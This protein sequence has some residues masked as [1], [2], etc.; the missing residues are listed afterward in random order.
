MATPKKKMVIGLIGGIG[1]GKSQAAAAFARRGGLIIDGDQLGH[2]ALRQPDIRRRIVE[3][4]GQDILDDSGEI[5]RHELGKVVFASKEDREALENLVHP[6]IGAAIRAD[7]A[8]AQD[9]PKVRF[10]ILDAAIMLE[11]GWHEVCD[12]LV[13]VDV[14]REIRLERIAQSRGWSEEKLA[15]REKAQLPLTQKAGRADHRLDNS[16]DLAHLQRQ[17]DQLLAA[18][19]IEPVVPA[20]E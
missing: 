12:K 20:R 1:S 18:L 6:W 2:Q 10:I 19:G 17:V 11:T 3:R 5:V 7:I 16:Q 15:L 4:W 13:F 8:R 14:P 9:D